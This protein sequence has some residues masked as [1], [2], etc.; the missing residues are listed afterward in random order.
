MNLLNSNSAL[1]ECHLL[2]Y[3]LDLSFL[4]DADAN[5]LMSFMDNG[6]TY[7]LQVRILDGTLSLEVDMVLQL[8]K[9]L[10]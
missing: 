9:I 5:A 10:F 6:E 8:H 2:Q 1:S 4:A 3:W 7:S